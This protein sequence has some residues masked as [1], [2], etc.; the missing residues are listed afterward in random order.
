MQTFRSFSSVGSGGKT[1]QMMTAASGL[2]ESMSISL[3]SM[4]VRLDARIAAGDA[5]ERDLAR[6][7]SELAAALEVVNTRLATR[8][9]CL[10]TAR[11][12]LRETD[13]QMGALTSFAIKSVA[14]AG[15]EFEEQANNLHTSSRALERGFSASIALDVTNTVARLGV[16]Q[17]SMSV[18][19]GKGNKATSASMPPASP[20][21]K[22]DALIKHPPLRDKFGFHS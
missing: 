13:A 21:R 2:A 11:G 16:S 20:M 3:R 19:A 12:S 18:A 22:R 1:D 14:R 6:Q 8:T 7:E 17:R 10:G 4:K 15:Y 5:R 9:A